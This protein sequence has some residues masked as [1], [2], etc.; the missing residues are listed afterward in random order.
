MNW[1]EILAMVF[2]VVII[3]GSGLLVLA[4]KFIDRRDMAP[5]RNAYER[6]VLDLLEEIARNTRR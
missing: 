3:G 5:A 6:R 1:V 2:V 4:N